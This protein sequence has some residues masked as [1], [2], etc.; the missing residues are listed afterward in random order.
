MN[1]LT[2]KKNVKSTAVAIVCILGFLALLLLIENLNLIM[3]GA[4][5]I[6]SPTSKLFMVLEKLLFTA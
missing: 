3:P 2:N 6:F 1:N 5:K 4:P